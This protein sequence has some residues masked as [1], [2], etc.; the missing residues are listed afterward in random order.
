MTSFS[1]C[2]NTSRNPGWGCMGALHWLGSFSISFHSNIK[3]LFRGL[4]WWSM[5]PNAGG[6][7]SIPGQRTKSHFSSCPQ[8]FPASGSSPMSWLFTLGGQSEVTQSCLNLY[9]PMDCSPPGSSVHGIFQARILEWV[10]MSFS[11]GS[12]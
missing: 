6:S 4:P 10:A 2:I 8:S 3:R 5:L 9:D 7:G 12:S 11:R 1:L